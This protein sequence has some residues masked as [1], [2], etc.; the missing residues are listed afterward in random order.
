M[1]SRRGP[2]EEKRD[3]LVD[4]AR[5]EAQTRSGLILLDEV[6][7]GRRRCRTLLA[8]KIVQLLDARRNVERLEEEDDEEVL[9]VSKSARRAMH[10]DKAERGTHIEDLTAEKSRQS[11]ESANAKA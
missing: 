2:V 5:G 6:G 1:G 4:V 7:D 3:A 10:A 11:A 8:S 9:R